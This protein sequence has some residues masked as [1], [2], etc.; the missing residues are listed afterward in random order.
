M[1]T[2]TECRPDR[3]FVQR[4]VAEITP[5]ATV[6]KF[7]TVREEGA[8]QVQRNL[9]FMRSFGKRTRTRKQ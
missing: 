9:L 6:K 1:K 4:R 2:E 5:E 3:E 7:L 8:R